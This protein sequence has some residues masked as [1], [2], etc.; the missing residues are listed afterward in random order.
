M[1]TTK[2]I[3]IFVL[4][5]LS[6]SEADNQRDDVLLGPRLAYSFTKNNKRIL[7]E[8]YVNHPLQKQ[9]WKEA[10]SSCQKFGM[11]LLTL[12]SGFEEDYVENLLLKSQEIPKN[13]H[14]KCGDNKTVDLNSMGT[15]EN[16][17]ELCTMM[18]SDSRCVEVSCAF[19]KTNFMCQNVKSR[20][21]DRED[22]ET[23]IATTSEEREA[24]MSFYH[25]WY[26]GKENINFLL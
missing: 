18:E 5:A 1:K 19:V 13:F 26:S 9:T 15:G 11:N 25:A 23:E 24:E 7:K 10:Q 2:L 14:V 17:N 22:L 20:D 16:E 4:C 8:V 6:G 12:K 3:T 21:I